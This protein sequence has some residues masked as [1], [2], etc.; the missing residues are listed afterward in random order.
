MKR[1]FLLVVVFGAVCACASAGAQAAGTP[2]EDARD[3]FRM[4]L[5]IEAAGVFWIAAEVAI[6]FCM[7]VAV[8]IFA[9]RRLPSRVSLTQREGKRAVLWALALGVLAASV[10][11]RHLLITPLP[12]A[13]SA[14]VIAGTDVQARV[15]DRAGECTRQGGVRTEQQDS[16]EQKAP[17][18]HRPFLLETLQHQALSPKRLSAGIMRPA[19]TFLV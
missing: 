1:F 2:I 16:D 18:T 3:Q 14:I 6:L 10:F 19:V 5:L 9:T 12:E 4:E 13:F 17:H 7:T 15:E 11:G 8:R